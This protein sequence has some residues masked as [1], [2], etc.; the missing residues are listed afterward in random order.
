[1]QAA[2]LIARRAADWRRRSDKWHNILETE[3]RWER[4]GATWP[5][6]FGALA[7]AVL[8][9]VGVKWSP[10]VSVASGLACALVGWR[11]SVGRQKLSTSQADK[12]WVV[13]DRLATQ[14]DSIESLLELLPPD[15][16]TSELL[17]LL[18]ASDHLE[19]GARLGLPDAVVV[20]L[21]LARKT[22]SAAA[23]PRVVVTGISGAQ[24]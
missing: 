15:S 18:E 8:L 2:K 22:M 12:V 9:L 21:G 16:T 5:I 4:R 19:N 14:Y 24:A 20:S 1:M 7:A 23:G 3:R 17:A 13:A 10:H 6:V 11:A